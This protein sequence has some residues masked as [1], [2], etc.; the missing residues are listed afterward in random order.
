MEHLSRV[1]AYELMN[2]I[3]KG[4]H[5]EAH[6]A[7]LLT[8]WMM[9]PVV[10]DELRGCM[11]AL[12]ELSVPFDPGADVIDL[13]GTGG[14][15]KNT[16]NISTLTSFVVA[17]AGYKVAKHGNYGVSSVSGS[18]T[19][20]EHF[21][22]TFTN[23][24]DTL[25]R[26]LD[27]YNICFLH[28]PLFHPALKHVGNVRRQLGMRT[29]FNM[30][31]PLVNPARPKYRLTGV[32]GLEL[33]RLYNYLLQEDQ[34]LR[35][36]IVHSLDGYDEISLTGRVKLYKPEGETVCTPEELQF[37]TITEADIYGGAT[38]EEAAAVFLSILEGKGTE[39]Q[40]SVVAANT[41]AAIRTVEPGISLSDANT[42]AREILLS[43]KALETFKKLLA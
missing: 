5:N 39:A 7:S 1:E 32:F 3:G 27:N 13:C 9:R 20:M 35:Y 28:A 34:D 25:K 19:V 14:D 24:Q 6:L 16:F 22:Y 23:D 38:K 36:T 17:A 42:K 12:V 26:Q 15:G 21:G 41:A 10:L 4:E 30:L 37:T 31:G 8:V 11:D 40:T 18:S 43:G 2:S 33:G 29:I